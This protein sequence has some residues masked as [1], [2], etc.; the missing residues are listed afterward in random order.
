MDMK[1]AFGEVKDKL[2]QLFPVKPMKGGSSFKVNNS[3]SVS[4]SPSIKK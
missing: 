1:V 4:K 3:N 2:K